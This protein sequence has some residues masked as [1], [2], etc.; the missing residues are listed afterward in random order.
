MFGAG[1]VKIVCAFRVWNG[2]EHSAGQL[3]RVACAAV[4]DSTVGVPPELVLLLFGGCVSRAGGRILDFQIKA[5][6]IDAAFQAR[7]AWNGECSN[8]FAAVLLRTKCI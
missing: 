2:V 1:E 3:D 8:V 4:E 5:G 7:V 6:L